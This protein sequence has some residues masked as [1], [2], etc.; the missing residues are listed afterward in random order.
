MFEVLAPLLLQ[1]DPEN[2]VLDTLTG[3]RE[4]RAAKYFSPTDHLLNM[5]NLFKHHSLTCPNH[6]GP[7]VGARMHLPGP[8]SRNRQKWCPPRL[9]V[10]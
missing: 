1:H 9:P 3:P 7:T 2:E 8:L 10:R 6:R 4:S 5:V